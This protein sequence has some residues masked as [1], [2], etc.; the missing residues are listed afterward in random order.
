MIIMVLVRGVTAD[1]WPVLRDIR[2]AALQDTPSAFGTTYAEAAA[3]TEEHWR[4]RAARGSMFFAHLP[5]VSTA[6]PVGLAGGYLSDPDTAHLISMW[7]DPRARGQRVGEAL[8][9]RVAQWAKDETNASTLCL[10]V[11]GGNES[12]LR[13]YERCGFTR[14]GERQPLPSDPSLDEVVMSRPL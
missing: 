8:I 10:W 13:L 3:L 12:A 6:K 14:T 2:L 5:E 7:V 4:E 11:T 9:G 1:E